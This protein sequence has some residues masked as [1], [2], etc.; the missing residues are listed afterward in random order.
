MQHRDNARPRMHVA[1]RLNVA[2]A[3]A[4]RKRV[5]ARL[6][7]SRDVVLKLFPPR[8]RLGVGRVK[9]DVEELEDVLELFAGRLRQR[10]RGQVV[11]V[12]FEMEKV[13]DFGLTAG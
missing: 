8:G 5:A 9:E 1:N 11:G 2:L 7:A 12:V 10:F 3:D 4:V 6:Q 13:D